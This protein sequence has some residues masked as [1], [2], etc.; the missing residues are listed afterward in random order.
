MTA[1]IDN[2]HVC[3]TLSCQKTCCPKREGTT[4]LVWRFFD[5]MRFKPFKAHV[6]QKPVLAGRNAT[7]PLCIKY[8]YW[9][10]DGD[11]VC[12]HVI[13]DCVMVV[14]VCVGVSSAGL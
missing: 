2:A 6:W 11:G 10:C 4:V 8:L 12:R 14:C 5:L 1:V 7:L 9:V 13:T 3:Y